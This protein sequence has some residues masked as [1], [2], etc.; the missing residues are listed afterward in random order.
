M[1]TGDVIRVVTAGYEDYR[2]RVTEITEV[3]IHGEKISIPFDTIRSLEIIPPNESPDESSVTVSVTV[4]FIIT[5]A[6]LLLLQNPF[7]VMPE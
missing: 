7:V 2:F 5:A 3:A 6:G 4:L 1:N